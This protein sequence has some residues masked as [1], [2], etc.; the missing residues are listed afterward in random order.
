MTI[1]PT[2]AIGALLARAEKAHAVYEQT[3]LNGVYDQDWPRW[4]AAFA[5]ENGIGE[6]LGR[7]GTSDSLANFLLVTY[8][9]FRRT[10][11]EP[12]EPWSAFTARRI[13]AD[14]W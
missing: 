6:L 8:D 13:V 7:V 12:D 4:Y 14:L 3:E 5:V 10:Q 2:D 1:D 9:E 11:A